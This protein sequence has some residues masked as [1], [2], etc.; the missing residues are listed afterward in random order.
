M[1]VCVCLL[2]SI[3]LST[4][5]LLSIF[6]GTLQFKNWIWGDRIMLLFFS[7]KN[8][9]YDNV[10]SCFEDTFFVDYFLDFFDVIIVFLYL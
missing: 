6:W 1:Y 5:I 4:S 2:Q 10:N 7:F 9:K 8:K 3:V